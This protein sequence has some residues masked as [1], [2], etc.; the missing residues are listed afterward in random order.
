MRRLEDQRVRVPQALR[1]LFLL[2]HAYTLAKR[3]AR[4][5]EHE[6]AARMLLRV[7][8]SALRFLRTRWPCSRVIECQR[9]DLHERI[10]VRE[11][12]AGAPCVVHWL[13]SPASTLCFLGIG[14][15]LLSQIQF[16]AGGYGKLSLVGYF[17]SPSE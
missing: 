6:G 3:L 8:C 10:R 14:T 2:L 4:R 16:L 5:G 1:H 15:V 7:A 9:A 12:A 11:R 13:V 17:L